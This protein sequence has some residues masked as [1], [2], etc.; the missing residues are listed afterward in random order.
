MRIVSFIV[1]LDSFSWVGQSPVGQWFIIQVI[2]VF[3]RVM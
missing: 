3:P 1:Q 2:L